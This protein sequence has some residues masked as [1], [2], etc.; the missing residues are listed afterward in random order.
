MKKS[1]AVIILLIILLVTLGVGY[2]D[3]WG[4][5]AY[6]TASASD[7]SLGLD[8]AGGVSSTYQVVGD[9]NPDATDM[10]DTIYKL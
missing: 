9:K 10:A 8:L 5:D 4:T 3:I 6:G 1:K 7:I 2:I